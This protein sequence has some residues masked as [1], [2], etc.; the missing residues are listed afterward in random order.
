MPLRNGPLPLAIRRERTR[1]FCVP[2][3]GSVVV[4]G[5]PNFVLG[6]PVRVANPLVPS[7]KELSVVW[8][9]LFTIITGFR[10]GRLRE[11]R[12]FGGDRLDSTR[13]ILQS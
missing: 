3:M 9:H 2:F 13:G 12:S 1:P 8:F 10:V 11:I 5:D 6:G 7:R 4:L